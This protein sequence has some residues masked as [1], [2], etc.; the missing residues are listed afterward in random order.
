[1]QYQPS[2]VFNAKAIIL[3]EQQWCYLT[4]SWEVH[5]FPMGI[6]PKVNVIANLE[7]EFTNY[8]SAVQRFNQYIT[9]TPQWK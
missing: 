5:A 7:F 2:W 4:Y 9:K 8:D 3:E 1:M 6:S